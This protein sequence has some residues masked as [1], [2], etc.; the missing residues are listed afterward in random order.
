M[1]FTT[2]DL[3]KQVGDPTGYWRA[4]NAAITESDAE[5]SL[6]KL[7]AEVLAA[8][9]R[10]SVEVV[11]DAPNFSNVIQ[12]AISSALALELDRALLLGDGL[13]KPLGVFD[14]VGV[15]EISMGVNGAA[16]TSYDPF[17]QAVEAIQTANGVATA[18]IYNAR[19]SGALDR[20]KSAIDA[21]PLIPP[22]SFQNLTRLVSNQIPNDQVHGSATNASCAFVGGF[23]NVWIGMR[24][25]LIV[26]VFR[27][28]DDDS[29]KSL[30]ILIRA[31]L[32]AD[33]AVVRPDHLC[34]ITGI[35]PA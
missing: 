30:Q 22:A 24:K 4:E 7:K 15:G 29:V 3:L 27:A 31:Y 13:G 2:L 16:L 26:E 8:L 28:G 25:Q 35:I 18:T 34:K 32:R 9:V 19:T 14:T 5:F 1:E 12:K 33:S 23:D 10:L 20:L 6:V 21:Q 11:E 17:S